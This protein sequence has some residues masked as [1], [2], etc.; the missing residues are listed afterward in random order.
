MQL[1]WY[2]REAVEKAWQYIRDNKANP[3][4]E[5][6]T[7]AGKSL[8]IAQLLLDVVTWGGRAML[9]AHRKELLEQTRDK[10]EQIAKAQGRGLDVGIYSAGLKQRDTQNA[11]VLAGIQSVHKR[12]PEFGRLNMVL[13]DEAHLIP[14]DGEGMFLGF[15]SDVAVIN[16]QVRVIGLTATPYRLKTGLVCGPDHILQE[17]CYRVG[18]KEL[19][20]QGYL[21]PLVSKATQEKANTEGLSVR[22]GEW[23]QSELQERMAEDMEKVIL[24]VSEL[25]AKTHDRHSCL[26]FCAGIE[27]AK[28]VRTALC[29][30]TDSV[31]YVDG[32]TPATLRDEVLE[33]FRSQ[34]IKYLANVDVLTTG[35]DATCVD[36]VALLRPT[37]SPGL[38]YQMVGR[39]LRLDPSKQDCLVLD[40]AGNVERHGPVDKIEPGHTDQAKSTPGEPLTKVCPSCEAIVPLNAR[41]CVDCLHHWPEPEQGVKHDTIASEAPIL[42]S[43]TW[44]TYQ[45]ESV[46]Y[47]VH[48][49]MD[50]PEGHPCTMRVEYIVSLATKFSEWVCVEHDGFARRKAEAWWEQRCS[51]P[52]PPDAEE[53]VEMA[54]NGYLA[55]PTSIKVD[56]S[57]K[58]PQVMQC[59]LGEIPAGDTVAN[60]PE[61]GGESGLVK[62][63]QQLFGGIPEDEL[64]F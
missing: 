38:Y 7:G 42:S 57:G 34:R 49:K 46:R 61:D 40:F 32:D 30:L 3:C 9:L 14:P 56:R 21:C 31:G 17:I 22:G 27:H 37:L 2:Q 35:F 4:I 50:A 33:A 55:E 60:R 36:C 41:V 26:I 19:I 51:L 12:A 29:E 47:Y 63:A 18:V 15:L 6:P 64:P 13:V 28:M 53:A 45:V 54:C 1:R 11:V 62:Q 5:L 59:E 23:V 8:V 58:Y 44:E 52:C 16:P 48:K 20:A 39:G 25:T 43:A 10:L 24:T